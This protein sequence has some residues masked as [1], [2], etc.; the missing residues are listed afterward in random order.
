MEEVQKHIRCRTGD[1]GKY[2]FI[3]GDQDRARKIAEHF[4]NMKE[5]ASNRAYH[6][7]TGTL[8]GVPVSSCATGIGGPS[9]SIAI[10]ELAKV[11][12]RYLIRVG[13]C[14]GRQK[15]I[16]IGSVVIATSAYRGEGTSAAYAP[17]PFPAVADLEISNALISAAK[18]LGY[19]YYSG[20]VFTRDAYYVQDKSLNQLLT[21]YGVVASEQECAIAYII[22]SI[23]KLHVGGILGT[24][25]NIWLDPQ[26]T[27]A[28]KQEL[29][30]FGE[31]KSIE[32]AIAAM[33][34][35]I[36]DKENL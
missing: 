7:Y 28:Q 24:D 2:V 9:A 31:K 20:T 10:E 3:P 1:V 18:E 30:K 25:S 23:R 29:F 4:D 6:V 22:G 35:I 34:K 14:G 11:G 13:S 27:L 5:V 33:K 8:N 36:A 15:D 17:L 19:D 32:I 26:P 21:D 12:A 16:P